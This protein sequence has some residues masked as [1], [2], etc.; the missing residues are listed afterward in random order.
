MVLNIVQSSNIPTSDLMTEGRSLM[1]QLKIVGPRTLTLR[2]SC[3]DVLE[4]R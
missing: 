2:D 3:R 1:K 4:L